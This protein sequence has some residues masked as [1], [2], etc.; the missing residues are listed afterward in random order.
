MEDISNDLRRAMRVLEILRELDSILPSQSAH[1]FVLIAAKPEQAVFEYAREI[2]ISTSAGSR[3]CRML[4]DGL[5]GREG[6]GVIR[7]I[8]DPTDNRRTRV[9]LTSKGKTFANRIAYAVR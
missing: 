3:I 6:Y 4:A 2:G 9:S 5:D 7:V 1:M 8:A